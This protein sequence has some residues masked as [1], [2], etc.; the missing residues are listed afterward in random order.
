MIFI[1]IIAAALALSAYVYFFYFTC[2]LDKPE[3]LKRMQWLLDAHEKEFKDSSWYVKPLFSTY[4]MKCKKNIDEY[5]KSKSK[6]DEDGEEKEE[7]EA[8]KGGEA[9]K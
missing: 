4:E 7:G 5:K 2:N 8:K 3:D 1:I 9:K 6:K